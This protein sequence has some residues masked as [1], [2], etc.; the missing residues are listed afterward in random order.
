MSGTM[1]KLGLYL[2][3]VE[4]DEE[5]DGRDR[6]YSD[7]AYDDDDDREPVAATSRRWAPADDLAPTTALRRAPE[8]SGSVRTR[9]SVALDTSLRA[10]RATGSPR[11]TRAP[12]T[13]RAR[14]AS[15]SATARR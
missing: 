3:L 1:R 13:R 2:G 9:G 14:S 8:L 7:D 15:T 12:T 5:L 4:D 6:R 10:A 11:C